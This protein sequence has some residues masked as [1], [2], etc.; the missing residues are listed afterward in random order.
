MEILKI[1]TK[2]ILSSDLNVE[3]KKT[4]KIFEICKKLKAD[5]YV[6]GPL[7]KNYLDEFLFNNKI[8]LS[9]FNNDE[10]YQNFDKGL[11]KYSII[12]SLS[13]Y[14]DKIIEYLKKVK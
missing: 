5:E 2:I 13:F 8:K 12:Q 14:G 9:Y 11:I 6:S 7:G 1:D 10:I 4:L 3:E